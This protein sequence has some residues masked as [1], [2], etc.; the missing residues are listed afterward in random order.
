MRIHPHALKRYLGFVRFYEELMRVPAMDR[1]QE[2]R[3][4][5]L[6]VDRRQGDA[7]LG[8]L[9][10]QEAI[11]SLRLEGKTLMTGM[12]DG[13]SPG[14]LAFYRR[15]GFRIQD[16]VLFRGRRVVRVL[17]PPFPRGD[18]DATRPRFQLDS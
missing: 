5:W 2:A 9:L 14:I 8:A 12:A 7:R 13:N 3:G 16:P 4:L 10:V 11:E 6:A 18:P 15:L 1:K 17:A